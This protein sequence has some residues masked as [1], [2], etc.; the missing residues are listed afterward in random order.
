MICLIDGYW[1][2]GKSTIRGLLDGHP[3]LFVCPVQDAVIGAFS[4]EK[5]LQGWLGCRDIIA[6][7]RF[8]GNSGYYRYERFSDLGVMYFE[9]SKND[10]VAKPFN[11][12]FHEFDK[13]WR[14]VLSRLERWTM[15]D[16]TELV[17]RAVPKF[18]MDWKRELSAVKYYVSMD[19]NKP[20]CPSF[21]V[22]NFSDGKYL[23][24]KRLPEGILSTRAGRIIHKDVYTSVKF[25]PDLTVLNMIRSGEVQRILS[26]QR[27]AEMLQQQYPDQVLVVEFEKF[28][29]DPE[30]TMRRVCAFLNIPFLDEMLRFSYLRKEVVGEYGEKFVGKVNDDPK[31]I[32]TPKDFDA[33]QRIKE[34][35]AAA[36]S[37]VGRDFLAKG[38]AIVDRAL[39]RA[40]EVVK[41]KNK[42]A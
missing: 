36:E 39:F 3:E 4:A 18:W 40:S 29:V 21:F 2:T 23:Y 28:V 5:E 32:L 19:D 20:T 34:V 13:S 6:L 1:G 12:D 14:S 31:E 11:F 38:L 26:V 35:M 17:Y 15:Q 10:R 27:Q 30:E 22:E 37:V 25:T 8:L 7:R 42:E 24:V 16:I 9:F 41:R 33:I